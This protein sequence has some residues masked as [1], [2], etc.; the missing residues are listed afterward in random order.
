[1][2]KI[3]AKR[4]K[5]A[6][7][8]INE[9]TTDNWNDNDLKKKY[10]SLNDPLHFH[11]VFPHGGRDVFMYWQS[12]NVNLA[13]DDLKKNQN[14]INGITAKIKFLIKSNLNQ[15]SKKKKLFISAVNQYKFDIIV[16][17]KC[18]YD[19]SDE[20]WDAVLNEKDDSFYSRRIIL[21]VIYLKTLIY[22]I[23]NDNLK[24]IDSFLDKQF[25]MVGK[26][27]SIKKKL[28]TFILGKISI[29]R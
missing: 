4:I 1:M 11:T 21:C 12:S 28:S 26:I 5:M 7:A 10:D 2:E 17:A 14:D 3:I 15:I 13:I 22:C 24:N 27:G 8:V 20:C 9:I 25:A 6:A 16:M 19:L 23:K 29:F 18:I